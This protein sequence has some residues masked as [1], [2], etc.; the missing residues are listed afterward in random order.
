MLQLTEIQSTLL[1]YYT[2]V[3][4]MCFV[5]SPLTF[6]KIANNLKVFAN[7]CKESTVMAYLLHIV[8]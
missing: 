7:R 4:L 8:F 5:L 1:Y 6:I 3:N 2:I